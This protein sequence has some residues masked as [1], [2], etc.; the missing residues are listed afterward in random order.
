MPGNNVDLIRRHCAHFAATG[1]PLWEVHAPDR[2]FHVWTIREGK[3]VRWS[4]HPS[5][6]NAVEAVG[7]AR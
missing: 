4:S 1:E 2:F 7:L 5:Q 3:I 6:A